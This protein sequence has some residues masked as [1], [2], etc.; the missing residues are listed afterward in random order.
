MQA[1]NIKKW[2]CTIYFKY[3]QI[4][5]CF[6]FPSP[7]SSPEPSR[8]S[9]ECGLA[10][11][12]S[13]SFDALQMRR[14]RGID[15]SCS[16]N[17][18]KKCRSTNLAQV[19]IRYL[20]AGLGMFFPF[21]CFHSAWWLFRSVVREGTVDK[22][23][24]HLWRILEE[25]RERSNFWQR[26]LKLLT[27]NWK[28]RLFAAFHFLARKL[29]ITSRNSYAHYEEERTS[30]AGYVTACRHAPIKVR[31][32]GCIDVII[33]LSTAKT[34]TFFHIQVWKSQEPFGFVQSELL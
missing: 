17:D 30:P 10:N 3:S 11:A 29:L 25:Q 26:F 13:Q 12:R 22:F 31:C 14:P 23:S 16:V 27:G 28:F 7:R 32:S 1:T 33:G 19:R 18:E 5:R 4:I 24:G 8:S 34:L 21:K 6:P 15:R 9:T 20:K 2:S